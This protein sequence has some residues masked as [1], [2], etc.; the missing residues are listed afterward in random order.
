[1]RLLE[2]MRI[3]TMGRE[4]NFIDLLSRLHI[5]QCLFVADEGG[6]GQEEAVGL[7]TAVVTSGRIYENVGRFKLVWWDKGS[8][9]ASK[10]GVSIWR[11]NVPARCAMLGDIVVKG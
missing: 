10:D 9:S 5:L 11:P 3:K 1:M 2:F 8:A 4:P 6:E 7:L